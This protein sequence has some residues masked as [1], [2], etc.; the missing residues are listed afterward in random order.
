MLFSPD[1]EITKYEAA[2]L[3]AAMINANEDG[4][5]SV[6]ATDDNIPIWAR[7][8]VAAMRSLGIF[9]GEDNVT[10]SDSV[11]RA[12]VAEFLYRLSKIR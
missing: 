4:E 3:I 8:S 6:F 12:D 5:E 7:S 1:E 11:T 9:T 10:L 2:K